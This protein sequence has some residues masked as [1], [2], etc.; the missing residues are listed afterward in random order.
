MVQVVDTCNT[1]SATQL[2]LPY[3]SYQQHLGSPSSNLVVS[4]QQVGLCAVRQLCQS[5]A[6][7][8]RQTLP[9]A[10]S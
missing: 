10:A 9:P 1:C 8:I 4:W 5:G 6:H 3:L 7:L 2:N